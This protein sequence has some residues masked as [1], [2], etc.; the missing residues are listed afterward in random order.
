VYITLD[1]KITHASIPKGKRK[2]LGITNNFIRVFVGLEGTEDLIDD[3]SIAL[4]L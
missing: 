4:K 1:L 3:F 2:K